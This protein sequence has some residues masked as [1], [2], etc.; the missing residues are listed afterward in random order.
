MPPIEVL[1]RT[2]SSSDEKGKSPAVIDEG[3]RPLDGQ[4]RKA[5]SYSTND[6]SATHDFVA[7]A[8]NSNPQATDP[9]VMTGREL[10]LSSPCFPRHPMPSGPGARASSAAAGMPGHDAVV[11]A[12]G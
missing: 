3:I 10:L 12:R 7:N 11:K 4:F 6:D 9:R 2:I 8:P 1:K 5:A